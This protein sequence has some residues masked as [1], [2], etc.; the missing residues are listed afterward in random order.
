ML[1]NFRI[2][3]SWYPLAILI[4]TARLYLKRI[5]STTPVMNVDE[6]ISL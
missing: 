1:T 6:E 4:A 2:L 5:S 3:E